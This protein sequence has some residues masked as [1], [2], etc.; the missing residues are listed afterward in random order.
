MVLVGW[1]GHHPVN[2][3]P[4]QGMMP[5]GCRQSCK[6]WWWG[7]VHRRTFTSST[8]PMSSHPCL[9]VLTSPSIPQQGWAFPRPY[10]NRGLWHPE[11]HFGTWA[12]TRHAANDG[13]PEGLPPRVCAV[14]YRVGERQNQAGWTLDVFLGACMHAKSLQSCP[15]LCDPMDS[16]PPGSSIHGIVQARILGC[17]ALLQGDLPNPGI[18]PGSFTFPALAGKNFTPSA[19][20]T[21]VLCWVGEENLKFFFPVSIF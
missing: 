20:C 11:L 12:W 3:H 4:G 15:T 17:H 8:G 16:S 13:H 5:A 21:G 19:P 10:R 18:E 7:G 14:G 9:F 6:R 1:G 2:L